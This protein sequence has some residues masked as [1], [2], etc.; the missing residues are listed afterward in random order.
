MGS[1]DLFSEYVRLRSCFC[2][3]VSSIGLLLI[4]NFLSS[5][6]KFPVH[7]SCT[8]SLVSVGNQSVKNLITCSVE[9]NSTPSRSK[10]IILYSMIYLLGGLDDVRTL[11]RKL[12]RRYM[13][14]IKEVYTFFRQ[15]SS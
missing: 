15:R 10:I 3:G 7:I 5:S 13:T 14:L 4:R 12:G 1:L 9:S 11:N 8:P 6:S 2:S